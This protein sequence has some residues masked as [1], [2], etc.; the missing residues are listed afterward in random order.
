MPIVRISQTVKSM[1]AG[2]RLSV[3]ANDPAFRADLEAWTRRL[4]HILVEFHEGTVQQALIE[5]R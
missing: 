2:E 3:E 5:K 1:A 4:G